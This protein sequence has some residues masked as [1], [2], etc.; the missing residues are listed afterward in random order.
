[1][2]MGAEEGACSC[3]AD[4]LSPYCRRPGCEDGRGAGLSPRHCLV[5][6]AEF[7]SFLRKRRSGGAIESQVCSRTKGTSSIGP[8]RSSRVRRRA[9][10]CHQ[11]ELV[12][13]ERILRSA[14]ARLPRWYEWELAAAASESAPDARQDP[15][16]RQGYWIGT[17]LQRRAAFRP[18]ANHPLTTMAC[19]ICTA[20]SGN[21]SRTRGHAGER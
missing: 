18:S 8:R 2:S 1:V 15:A 4:D 21:G 11:R 19:A 12:R 10:T 17:R 13:R 20:W 5:S 6:N 7:A 3:R 9:A 16:W 14:R